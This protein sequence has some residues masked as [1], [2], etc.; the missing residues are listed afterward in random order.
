MLDRFISMRVFVQAAT[1]GSLSAAGRVMDMSP[2]MATKHMDAL[3]AR[4]G[5]KLLHRTTRKLTLTDAG[6]EFLES[7]RSILQE[8][9]E[10]EAEVSVQ[11][12][13][14][15]GR[16]RMNLP[17]S[18]GTRFIAPLLPEF[19]RRYPGIDVEVGLSDAQHDLIREGWDLGIRIGHLADSSLKA[20]RLGN[21]QLYVCAS[22]DYL[23]RHGRPRRVAD[24]AEHN[25]LGYT[26][27]PLQGKGTWAFGRQ[28]DIKVPVHGNLTAN[29]GDALLAAAVGGQGIIYQPD[30]IVDRAIAKGELVSL[31][32]DQPLV[33]LGGLYV[34]FPPDRRLPAK[35]R[36]MIDFLVEQL[37][38]S[39]A[40]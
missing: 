40:G 34:M 14:A 19:S 16:L 33:E 18:F 35:V 20:R 37:V 10:A 32:L 4:L 23:A 21:C 6:T 31:E 13:E 9:D 5:V 39:P 11:R 38:G 12:T 30:F 15:V 1:H 2:A 29:N 22:P 36:L 24:L 8:L 7:C 26:L 27:S 25:C 17:H 28:G 3:E